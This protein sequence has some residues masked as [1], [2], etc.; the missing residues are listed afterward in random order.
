MDSISDKYTSTQFMLWQIFAGN[1][2]WGIFALSKTLLQSKNQNCPS[3]FVGINGA[4]AIGEHPSK[5]CYEFNQHFVIINVVK[6]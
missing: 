4:Q 3:I 1:V 2:F 6:K 5:I